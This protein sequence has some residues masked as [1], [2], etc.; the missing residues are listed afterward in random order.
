MPSQVLSL[1]LKLSEYLAHFGQA[2]A[3]F[4]TIFM[5]L[6]S[7]GKVKVDFGGYSERLELESA[8]D[9]MNSAQAASLLHDFSKAA[10]HQ[11]LQ[12][13][14]STLRISVPQM[15]IGVP[16]NT[17]ETPLKEGERVMLRDTSYVGTITT[18]FMHH[19]GM[20]AYF[21][22]WDAL[23]GAPSASKSYFGTDLVP[24]KSFRTVSVKQNP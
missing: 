10:A 11:T 21:V 23:P 4:M 15:G 16:A 13:K 7:H 9:L 14:R 8:E 2:Y 20:H 18:A 17:G 5:E 6:L 3:C 12:K 22:S 1:Q 19:S 24:V